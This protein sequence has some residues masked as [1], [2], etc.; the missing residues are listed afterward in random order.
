M[1]DKQDVIFSRFGQSYNFT[2]KALGVLACGSHLGCLACKYIT[3]EVA[4]QSGHGKERQIRI[5]VEMEE[6]EQVVCCIK[7]STKQRSVS[8][9]MM[10]EEQAKEESQQR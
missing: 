4:N 3:G 5:M 8:R 9:I 1:A 7:E 6:D 10:K 2:I